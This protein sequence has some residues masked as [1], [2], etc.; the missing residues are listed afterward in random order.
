MTAFQT[1]RSWRESLALYLD[2]RVLTLLF[3]GFS[4]G[5]PFLLVFSTLTAWLADSGVE[6]ATIGFFSWVGITYSIKV[7]WAPVVDRLRLP[8]LGQLLGQRRG[9]LLLAQIG[10]GLGLLAMSGLNPNGHITAIALI[11]LMVAFSSA[12][13][14]IVIDA[15]RIES[16]PD[17]IQA[18]MAGTYI[19]GYRVAVLASG[20]GAFYLADIYDWQVSYQIM[21]ACVSVGIITTLLV[22]E[23]KRDISQKTWES[24]ERVQAFLLRSAHW[25]RHVRRIVADLIGAVVCPFADFVRRYQWQALTILLLVGLYKVSDISMAAMANPFYLDLGFTKSEIASVAKVFGFGASIIGGLAGG[26]FVARYGIAKVLLMGAILVATTN[27][28]FA[29]VATIG[30]ELWALFVVI[31]GDNFSNGFAATAFI[32]WLSSLVNRAYTAT[33]Y[34]LF[35][36]L[37]TLPGKFIAGYSGVAVE[38]YGYPVFF[39]G[40]AALGVPA[41]LLCVWFIARPAQPLEEASSAPTSSGDHRV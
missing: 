31:G 12:T 41:I 11:A 36:S 14:D 38:D 34:A 24:E 21:A 10:I 27:L 20:A 32:A 40:V 23:P 9:W 17:H 18:A 25:N 13:Q 35:S 16:A 19:L 8:L 2:R 28:L 26:V 6:K 5:L 30:H 33:Q 4:A 7:L 37:M 29:W 1:Q 39:I 15:F 22:R 3:L